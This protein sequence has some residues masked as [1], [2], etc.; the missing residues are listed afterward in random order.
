M[1]T[2]D[3]V[4]SLTPAEMAERTGVSIDTLRYYEREGLINH[5][6][7]ADS[8]H[9]RYSADDVLWV[10]VLR[11]LRETGMTIEQ[12]RH[13]CELGE[14]GEQTRPERL[15][16]LLDHRAR[17]ERQMADLRDAL[18][19]IDHKIGFYSDQLDESEAS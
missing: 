3:T 7:R 16:L 1:T 17:V 12:L 18:A 8:G 4:A 19:L 6:A 5:V 11:C 10:E 2:H 9:R 15:Q 14:Q 13:Y